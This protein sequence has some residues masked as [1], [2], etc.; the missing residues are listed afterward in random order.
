MDEVNTKC[1]LT[2]FF[3]ALLQQLSTIFESK[4]W[5]ESRHHFPRR[6]DNSISAIYKSHFVHKCRKT[7]HG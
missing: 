5:T 3:Q 6:K 2:P 4:V 1:S 7:N